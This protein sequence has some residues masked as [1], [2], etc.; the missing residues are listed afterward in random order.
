MTGWEIFSMMLGS[1]VLAS[2][3]TKGIDIWIHNNKYKKE[4]YSLIINKR[5]DAYT[6]LNN[7]TSEL[8]QL[9]VIENNKFI[10]RLLNSKNEFDYHLAMFVE[11]KKLSTWYSPTID[12][13][14]TRLNETLYNLDV[15]IRDKEVLSDLGDEFLDEIRSVRKELNTQITIDFKQLYDVKG[16]LDNQSKNTELIPINLTKQIK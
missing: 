3:L 2:L 8:S 6:N 13:I 5:L 12:R 1:S 10:P 4:Y 15:R 7:F 14:L 9:V 16:F 11:I